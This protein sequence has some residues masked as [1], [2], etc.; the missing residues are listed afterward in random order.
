MSTQILFPAGSAQIPSPKAAPASGEV[1][2]DTAYGPIVVEGLRLSGIAIG[3]P[4]QVSH[5]KGPTVRVPSASATLFAKAAVVEIDSATDLAVADTLGS[6][7]IGTA[8][9]AKTSGQ[10]SVDVVLGG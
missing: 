8:A 9:N 10:T 7:D 3:D 1:L 4:I 2:N 6:F 5:G